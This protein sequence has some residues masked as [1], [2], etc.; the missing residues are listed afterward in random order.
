MVG[1]RFHALMAAVV[2]RLPFGLSRVVA[3]SMLGFAVI[4][5]FTFSVDLGLLTLAHRLLHWPYPAAVTVSYLTA[6][7]LS[8]VLN[9]GFN[10][11]SHGA[12]GQQTARY[13]VAVGVNYLVFVLGVGTGLTAVGVGYALARVLSGLLEGVYMYCVMR[14]VVFQDAAAAP[15]GA[16]TPEPT[17]ARAAAAARDSSGARATAAAD[18]HSTTS[19]DS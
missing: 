14:W 11:Q 15:A 9:R 18:H 3:P 19:A 17:A 6:F 12:L 16:A 4:N 7:A 13:V 5:G 2:R 1:H 10:F 8:F